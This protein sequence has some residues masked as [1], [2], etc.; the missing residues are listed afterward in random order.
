MEWYLM[1]LRNYAT[2]S[3]RSRRKEYWMFFLINISIAVLLMLSSA[4]LGPLGGLLY[5]LYALGTI[6]PGIALA[7]RRLQDQDKDWYWIFV[8]LVPLV[9]GIW[10]IVLMATEGTR[11]ENRF[12]ADPKDSLANSGEVLDA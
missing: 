2:F 11:G 4:V 3:G 5:G 10:L 7:V 1:A 8:G 6:L 12:G 9:G